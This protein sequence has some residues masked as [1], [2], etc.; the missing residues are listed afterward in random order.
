MSTIT[1][2]IEVDVPVRTAYDQWTQ[3]E[4]FPRFMKAVKRVEQLDDKR[5]RWTAE[6]GGVERT[7]LAEITE[8]EPDR[9]V[10]WRSIEGAKNAGVVS[11]E[12]IGEGRTRVTLEL[13]VEPSDAVEKVGDAL[14]FVERQA[15]EDLKHFKEFIE[16]RRQPTGAWRGE[17]HDGE[18]EQD[19]VR[20]RET[21]A[22]SR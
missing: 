16:S 18:V 21:G 17:V 5:L 10:A 11:F 19:R 20:G 13:D 22:P 4:E 2:T 15:E 14:G 7:W 12:P 8:Q 6:I 9:R 3:F 1:K